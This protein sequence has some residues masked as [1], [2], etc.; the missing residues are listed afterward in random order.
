MDDRLDTTYIQN[1]NSKV[2]WFIVQKLQRRACAGKQ[3]TRQNSDRTS[4]CRVSS[5]W[6][7]SCRCSLPP[8]PLILL[9]A[10]QLLPVRLQ[11]CLPLT[12]R[13]IHLCVVTASNTQNE[14]S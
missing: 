7:R 13:R 2:T 1:Q 10:F 5:N 4:S 6:H 12:V 9:F 14:F 3:I 8:A 11:S